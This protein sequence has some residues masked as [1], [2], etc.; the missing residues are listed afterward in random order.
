LGALFGIGITKFVY[1]AQK[2]FILT[3]KDFVPKLMISAK[4]FNHQ[5]F[6]KNVIKDTSFKTTNVF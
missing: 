6:V 4:N 3:K 2:D 5:E 1:N